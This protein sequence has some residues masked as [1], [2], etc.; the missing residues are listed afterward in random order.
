MS[1]GPARLRVEP[2]RAACEHPSVRDVFDHHGQDL[3]SGRWPEARIEVGG[4]SRPW[5]E[6]LPF[7]LPEVFR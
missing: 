6:Y 2:L 5:Q 1:A 7:L 4:G 3:L